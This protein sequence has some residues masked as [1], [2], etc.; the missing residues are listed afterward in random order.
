MSAI[1]SIM[2]GSGPSPFSASRGP[3]RSSLIKVD[4]D[5]THSHL[6]VALRN[7]F[8]VICLFRCIAP[9]D[10]DKA[11]LRGASSPV[12]WS[13]VQKRSKNHIE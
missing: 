10:G 9:A 2:T 1:S 4:S 7:A 6:Q 5:E 11:A 8:D 13:T 3:V 12:D